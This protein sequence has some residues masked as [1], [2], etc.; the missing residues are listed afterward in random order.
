MSNVFS[1]HIASNIVL[2][3]SYPFPFLAALLQALN[4]AFAT[5]IPEVGE[6]SNGGI[7]DTTEAKV[8]S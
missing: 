5:S 1:A 7:K 8:E 2:K 4:L 3:A 6:V